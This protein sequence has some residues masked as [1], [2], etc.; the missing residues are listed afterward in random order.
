MTSFSLKMI[1]YV[2][3][4]R[5]QNFSFTMKMEIL[6]SFETLPTPTIQQR[7]VTQNTKS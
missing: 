6:Y 5:K 4:Y 2:H 3:L 7:V 1:F